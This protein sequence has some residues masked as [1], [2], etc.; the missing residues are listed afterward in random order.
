MECCKKANR[1]VCGRRSETLRD[2][3]VNAENFVFLNGCT[4]NDWYNRKPEK[5]RYIDEG[6]KFL[7]P[8][9]LVCVVD[10]Q[11]VQISRF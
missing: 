11:Y 9:I 1:G 2:Y 3:F 8:N 10:I 6:Y 5:T 4:F 7:I